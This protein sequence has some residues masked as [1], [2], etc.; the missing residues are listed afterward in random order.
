[1]FIWDLKSFKD[2]W[3]SADAQC[4]ALAIRDISHLACHTIDICVPMGLTEI[5][6]SALESPLLDDLYT[7]WLYMSH[8]QGSTISKCTL[9][10][11]P[12]RKP[13]LRLQH[14]TSALNNVGIDRK[15]SYAGHSLV[16][17]HILSCGGELGDKV[18]VKLQG[19]GDYI[20]L[21]A[22]SGGLTYSTRDSIII[23]YYK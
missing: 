7:V 3:S 21:S 12:T 19:C 6:L 1:M 14:S 10:L 9:A 20:H 4:R 22:Y 5:V 15:I 11:P 8:H 16:W 23:K 18:E 13:S 2:H 17:N